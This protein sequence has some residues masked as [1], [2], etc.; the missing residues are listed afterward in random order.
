MLGTMGFLVLAA[1]QILACGV[2]SLGSSDGATTPNSQVISLPETSRK[3]ITAPPFIFWGLPKTDNSGTLYFHVDTGSYR[4]TTLLRLS[5]R[6]GKGK[7]LILPDKMKTAVFVGYFVTREGEVFSLSRQGK[8][9]FVTR[10]GRTGD[11][12]EPVE[13]EIPSDV[14]VG[15]FGVFV[16]GEFLVSGF[17]GKS[18]EEQLQGRSFAAILTQDGKLKSAI[19]DSSKKDLAHAFDRA[20][21][22]EIVPGEDGNLYLVRSN[23]TAVFT[24]SGEPIKNFQYSPPFDGCTAEQALISGGRLVFNCGKHEEDGM[25]N[26]FA[27]LDLSTGLV[28][29]VYKPSSEL[30]NVLVQFSR[31]LGF[32]FFYSTPTS[33]ELRTAAFP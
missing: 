5:V 21:D 26:E 2:A 20:H 18:A 11:P 1:Q 30:G 10:F 17:Y 14:V 23:R 24:A 15:D 6:D 19:K 7:L 27:V 33:L 32:T 22:G 31:E 8:S 25:R 9:L 16:T 28:D 13:M 3:V 12:G 29:R 4:S